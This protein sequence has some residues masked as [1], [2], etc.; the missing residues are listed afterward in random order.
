M[1]HG[2]RRSRHDSLGLRKDIARYVTMSNPHGTFLGLSEHHSR[3]DT[4]RYAVLP[5]PYE[6]TTSYKKG[7]AAGP[8]AILEASTQVEFYDDELGGEFYQ[9]G[10]AT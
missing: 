4:S 5:V 3:L 1:D 9:A 7:T 6:A 10:I 8:M 2:D